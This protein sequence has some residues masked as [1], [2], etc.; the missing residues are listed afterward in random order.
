MRT[1]TLGDTGVRVTELSFDAAWGAGIRS[2]DTDPHYG[3]GLTE[4]RLGTACAIVPDMTDTVGVSLDE[5]LAVLKPQTRIAT[6]PDEPTD[7]SSADGHVRVTTGRPLR[8]RACCDFSHLLLPGREALAYVRSHVL[9][10]PRPS[11]RT[12]RTRHGKQVRGGPTRPVFDGRPGH[13]PEL[14]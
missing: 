14:A 10:W 12:G 6:E 13:R 1:S 3:L 8:A 2:F 4:R 11:R 7:K 9:S 5:A